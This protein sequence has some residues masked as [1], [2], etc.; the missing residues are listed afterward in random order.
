MS[1]KHLETEYKQK[2]AL[3]YF[4]LSL[5]NNGN[6]K[7]EEVNNKILSLLFSTADTGL[8]KGE[9]SSSDIEKIL[10]AMLGTKK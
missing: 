7:D 6:L 10:Y 5:I 1:S 2:Y 9:T 8:I 3:T 4:Y